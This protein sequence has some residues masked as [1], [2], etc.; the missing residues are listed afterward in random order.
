[1]KLLKKCVFCDCDAWFLSKNK[2]IEKI[3]ICAVE[4]GMAGFFVGEGGNGAFYGSHPSESKEV[5]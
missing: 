2:F 1:M 4:D 5:V 3:A